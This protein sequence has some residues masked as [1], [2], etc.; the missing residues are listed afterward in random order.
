MKKIFLTLLTIMFF[1]INNVAALETTNDFNNYKITHAGSEEQYIL[2]HQITEQRLNQIYDKRANNNNEISPF[3]GG[4]YN[5]LTYFG[6]YQNYE[7]ET[8]YW[9]GPATIKQAVH[10][11]NGSSASQQTYATRMGTNSSSGTYVY[12]MRNEMNYRQSEHS[13]VYT[14]VSTLDNEWDLWTIV[15]QDVWEDRVPVIIHALTDVLYMYN[16]RNLGHYITI[17]G[18]YDDYL[19][20]EFNYFEYVDT[21][22]ANYGRGNVMG[23]HTVGFYELYNSLH[24]SGRYVI[25]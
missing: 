16:G 24:D 6:T 20:A 17:T 2:N 21:Y 15:T 5:S 25:W 11:I 12:K 4:S 23:F 8:S 3:G 14:D 7:Q 10:W 18:Y 9:C 19:S 13:Y 1:G 22:N